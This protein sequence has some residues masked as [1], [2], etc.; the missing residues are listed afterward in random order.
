MFAHRRLHQTASH[1][2]DVGVAILERGDVREG[3]GEIDKII[4]NDETDHITGVLWRCG[5]TSHPAEDRCPE[6][7]T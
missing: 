6:C 7:T 2:L 4:V 5:H 3:G 1:L